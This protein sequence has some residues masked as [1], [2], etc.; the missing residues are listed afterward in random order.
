MY[1]LGKFNNC[2]F[3]RF[4]SPLQLL[5]LAA[6][7]FLPGFQVDA[8]D[9]DAFQ[10]WL[11]EDVAGTSIRTN[12]DELNSCVEDKASLIYFKKFIHLLFNRRELRV[13]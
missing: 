7:S 4:F 6:A 1:F 3:A 2:N 10:P 9:L 5:L 11:E 13:S 12:P 8:K